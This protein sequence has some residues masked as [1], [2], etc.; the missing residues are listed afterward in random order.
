MRTV[1]LALAALCAAALA[2]CSSAPEPTP[3]AA[4]P[5]T[6]ASAPTSASSTTVPVADLS[7]APPVD[8]WVQKGNDFQQTLDLNMQPELI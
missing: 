3:V 8:T 2:A 6:P 1:A 4:P 5:T 7:P